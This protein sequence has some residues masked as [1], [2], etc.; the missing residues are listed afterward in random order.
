MKS[1]K[2]WTADVYIEDDVFIFCIH[3]SNYDYGHT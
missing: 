1:N 3:E 2:Y